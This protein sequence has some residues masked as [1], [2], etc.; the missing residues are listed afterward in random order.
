MLPLRLKEYPLSN[1]IKDRLKINIKIRIV[2]QNKNDSLLQL[3]L[4]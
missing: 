1:G 4:S 2:L 3:F